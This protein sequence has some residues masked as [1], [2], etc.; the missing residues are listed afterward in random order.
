[1]G[2]EKQ[3]AFKEPRGAVGLGRACAHEE[4]RKRIYLPGEEWQ[5]PWS[6]GKEFG[7]RIGQRMAD[8]L[9]SAG[10]GP[11][12]RPATPQPPQQG[13]GTARVQKGTPPF[14][15]RRP[16]PLWC[17]SASPFGASSAPVPCAK[18]G[19]TGSGVVGAKP[20]D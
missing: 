8:L 17:L 20:A 12:G 19:N 13:R 4:G 15:G 11:V 6:P 3:I 10:G 5:E 14:S 2:E 9:E 7:F 16:I 18:C 1:M